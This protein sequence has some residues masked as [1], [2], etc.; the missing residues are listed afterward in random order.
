M[1]ATESV[2]HADG[3]LTRISAAIVENRISQRVASIDWM[4]GLVMPAVAAR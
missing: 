1:S 4:R 3:P 2:L